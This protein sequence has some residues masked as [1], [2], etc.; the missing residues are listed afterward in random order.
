MTAT[1]APRISIRPVT[2]ADAAAIARWRYPPPYEMYSF[3]AEDAEWL[4]R[5]ELRYPA[6]YDEHHELVGY[7]CYGEDARIPAA[8][9]SGLY[10]DVRLL[11]VGLGMRP[12]RTSQG[13]GTAFLSAGLKFGERTFSPNGFRLTVAEWN[14]RA[15][16]LYERSGFSATGAFTVQESGISFL[17]MTRLSLRNDQARSPH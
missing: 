1:R 10:A 12:D 14:S 11:D 7:F 16:R 17:V 13:L 8:V 6:A 2:P 5:P 4:L 15:V 9:E 3:A